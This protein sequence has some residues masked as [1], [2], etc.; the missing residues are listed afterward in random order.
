MSAYSPYCAR[1]GGP[2]DAT[3]YCKA[4]WRVVSKEFRERNKERLKD[5][6]KEQYARIRHNFNTWISKSWGRLNERTINGSRPNWKNPGLARYLKKGVE[7]RMTRDEFIDKMQEFREVYDALL[8]AGEK[9]S[10]DRIDSTKHYQVDNIQIISHRENARR[11]AVSKWKQ[12]R[13]TTS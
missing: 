11:G 4:C 10:I 12:I 1:C 13:E 2:K 8:I 3:T 9:P 5:K 6:S 7:L